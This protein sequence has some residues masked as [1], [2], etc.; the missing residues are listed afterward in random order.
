MSLTIREI[1][2]LEIL[3]SRGNPTV[4]VQVEL[5]DATAASAKVPSGASTGSHEA[6]ELRDG[7]SSRYAGKGVRK[8]L[9]NVTRVILPALRGANADDQTAIDRRMIELDGT[10][11]K[12]RLGANAILG[13][14]CAVARAVA[15][16]GRLP[17]WRYLA[18]ERRAV[19]PVPMVNILSGGL[20]AGRNFEFQDFLAV[21]LGFA[22]YAE[23]LEAIVAVHRAARAVLEKRGYALTGVA[24]EGGW[25]PRLPTNE[26]AL[27]VMIEAIERAS[28]HPGRQ[29]AIAIDVAASHFFDDGKYELQTEGRSLTSAEM[30]DLLRGWVA[31]YPVISIEDGLAEDDWSGWQ[32][33]TQALGAKAQLIGDDLF[34]TNPQRLERGIRERAANAV[35]V[36][37]NQIGTLT[38]TFQVIDRARAAGFRAVISARSGETEDDFL[39]DLAVASGAGQIK[40]GSITRSERLAKYNRLLEIEAGGEVDYLHTLPAG[41]QA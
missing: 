36:K 37:M 41:I 38:E 9:E 28:Y 15:R 17:L 35:L 26:T 29:M 39:S 22:T 34:A 30:I 40:V 23:A 5:S 16:S 20:H 18:G 27:D 24:D 7:D 3:D 11:N 19:L 21:P 25:G 32:R 12:S 33:L 14:S 4:M 31:R 8:A 1:R 10:P 2:A 13:V 6:I